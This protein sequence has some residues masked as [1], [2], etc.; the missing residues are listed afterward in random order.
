MSCH[1][2][3]LTWENLNIKGAV[4]IVPSAACDI[5]IRKNWCLSHSLSRNYI[6]IVNFLVQKCFNSGWLISGLDKLCKLKQ[7]RAIALQFYESWLDWWSTSLMKALRC[8]G[9]TP[10]WAAV[11]PD[12]LNSQ[13]G[14]MSH[15]IDQSLW[16]DWWGPSLA[17][18]KEWTG[19]AIFSPITGLLK[20][21]IGWSPW[22]YWWNPNL[23]K[24]PYRT[25]EDSDC[26][27]PKV[28][29]VKPQAGLMRWLIS[30]SASWNAEGPGDWSPLLD[31]TILD[32]WSPWLSKDPHWSR[33]A[34]GCTGETPN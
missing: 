33:E 10:G 8:C 1:V 25:D 30:E 6:C 5:A 21:L 29:L 13:A 11:A 28:G 31:W 22:L 18:A 9:E 20:P 24:A 7:T 23:A 2:S 34:P 15:L 3:F 19:E 14:L 27:K 26:A 12:W 16:F 4:I 17:K 32:W